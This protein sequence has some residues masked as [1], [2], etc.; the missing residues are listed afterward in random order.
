MLSWGDRGERH[1][2]RLAS[3]CYLVARVVLAGAVLLLVY[4]L[5]QWPEQSL[6]VAELG[7]RRH[8]SVYGGSRKNFTLVM[9]SALRVLASVYG[10]LLK[11][12]P[13][14]PT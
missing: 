13:A 7:C 9:Q 8:T 11:E 12:F 10:R 5:T 6:V 1:G 4:P 14:L 3:S 2:V